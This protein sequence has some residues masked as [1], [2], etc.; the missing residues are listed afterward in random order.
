MCQEQ[1]LR[2]A[3]SVSE[4]ATALG[5]SD[6]LVRESINRGE[7]EVVRMQGRIL[8][9]QWSVDRFLRI[10]DAGALSHLP[11]KESQP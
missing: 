4:V 1:V 5:V 9:P 8:V 6:W 10:P 2:F 11:A 3:Y 7:I